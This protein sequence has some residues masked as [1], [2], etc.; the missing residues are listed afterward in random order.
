MSLPQLCSET[1]S[2]PRY[3]PTHICNQIIAIIQKKLI[4]AND[5]FTSQELDLLIYF[6]TKNK[7]CH[8]YTENLI[9]LNWIKR[10]FNSDKI[11]IND[12]LLYCLAENIEIFDHIYTELNAKKIN[13]DICL[14][15]ILSKGSKNID[16]ILSNIN[17]TV[18]HLE[19]ACK[20]KTN[21]SIIQKIIFNKVIPNEKCILNAFAIQSTEIVELLLQYGGELTLTCLN[22]AC[23]INHQGFLG[24][25]LTSG[26]KPCKQNFTSIFQSA[27]KNSDN[28][29]GSVNMLIAHG[30]QID[31]DDLLTA[32]EHSILIK[33]IDRYKFTFD[34]NFFTKCINSGFYPQYPVVYPIRCL[35][36]EC[37]KVTRCSILLVNVKTL[38]KNGLKPDTEC[39]KNACNGR[40]N[41]ELIKLLIKHGG[42]PDI[43]CLKILAIGIGNRPMQYLADI[44]DKVY[45]NQANITLTA[46]DIKDIKDINDAN[47]S[48]DDSDDDSD[49]NI[50]M[51][52]LE[53]I[54]I[55]K[56]DG[57]VDNTV[58]KIEQPVKLYDVQEV[59]EC[60]TLINAKEKFTLNDKGVKLFNAK[61]KTEIS[62]LALRKKLLTYIKDNDLKDKDNQK[63]IKINDDMAKIFNFAKDKFIIFSDIDKLAT[64]I[65]NIKATKQIVATA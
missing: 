48:N 1:C 29:S 5:R 62:F 60:L 11:H 59:K 35:H 56:N 58:K 12:P 31:Y 63:Y 38:I 50:E 25:C 57:T 42:V 47:K 7:N 6:Y 33:N 10:I 15:K 21:M 18:K 36:E 54:H 9:F 51:K 16:S 45:Q 46:K 34:D 32:T 19:W 14:E 28:L 44:V 30:Y 8:T 13:I 49:S 41:Y 23:L 39:I 3:R 20:A 55:A 24:L 52:K 61:K 43:S 4:T 27:T 17:V 2:Y 40:S 26:L 65:I 53:P 22:Y 64:N 37:K